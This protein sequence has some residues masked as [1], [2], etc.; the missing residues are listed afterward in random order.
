ML[1]HEGTQLDWILMSSDSQVLMFDENQTIMPGDIPLDTIKSL[2]VER[3]N[4]TNQLRVAAGDDYIS[5]IDEILN[6]KPSSRKINST[7]YDLRVFES[8]REMVEAI[9]EPIQKKDQNTVWLRVKLRAMLG[10]GKL[11]AANKTTTLK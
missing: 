10:T 9:R 7:G 1:G 11:D 5:F 8:G 2:V 4:L 6:A 3:Y